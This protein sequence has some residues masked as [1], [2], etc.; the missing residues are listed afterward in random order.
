[1]FFL[2]FQNISSP[3]HRLRPKRLQLI[4]GRPRASPR[5]ALVPAGTSWIIIRTKSLTPAGF[6]PAMVILID[7]VRQVCRRVFDSVHNIKLFLFFKLYNT[8]ITKLRLALT[9]KNQLLN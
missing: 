4:S 3:R 9:I 6:N 1:M 2:L 5:L 7:P 8:R